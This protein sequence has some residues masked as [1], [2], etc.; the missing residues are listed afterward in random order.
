MK[1]SEII[2]KKLLIESLNASKKDAESFN[3]SSF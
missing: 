2:P 3:Q 1:E